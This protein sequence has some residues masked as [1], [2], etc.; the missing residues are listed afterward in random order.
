MRRIVQILGA[1]A[2]IGA[3][4]GWA[5]TM[6]AGLPDEVAPGHSADLE[7]GALVFA[8]AGCGSCHAAPGGADKTVLAGGHALDSPFGTFYA[9]NISSGPQGIGGWTLPEFTRALRDGVSPEGQHY[10]PAFPYTSYARMTDTD[11]ADLFAYL[12]TLPADPT[13][14][15]AHDLGFPFTIRRGIGLWKHLYVTTDPVLAGDLDAQLTRGRYLVEVLG[16]CAECHTAR[17]ALGGLDRTAWM[18]G[19]PNPSGKGRI[20][21]IRPQTLGWSQADLVAYF[22]SGFTPDY[23]S[24]GGSMAAVVD[25]LAQLPE[26]DRTAIAAY[27]L[28]LP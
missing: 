26:A 6:P 22:T 11:V 1:C 21:D 10:Y 17:D 3:G 24:V 16:H 4:V 19:A 18:A 12:G 20:P 28:A 8:A 2:V 9:P 15:R 7:N 27:L 5:L 25:N 14:D 13:P 23:D